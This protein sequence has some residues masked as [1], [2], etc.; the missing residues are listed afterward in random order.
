[1]FAEKNKCKVHN[2]DFL[3]FPILESICEEAEESL[4]TLESG[5]T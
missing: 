5:P 2:T 4:L 1:M 3:K